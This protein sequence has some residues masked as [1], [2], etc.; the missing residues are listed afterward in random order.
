MINEISFAC[1][2]RELTCNADL[3]LAKPED[4]E[5]IHALARWSRS[6][7]RGLGNRSEY[8]IIL[9]NH[10]FTLERC[11]SNCDQTLLPGGSLSS[12]SSLTFPLSA[13]EVVFFLAVPQKRNLPLLES[14]CGLESGLI[15]RR[16]SNV[17]N[18]TAES[19]S[20]LT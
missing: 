19:S 11:Q 5:G 14:D 15:Y 16:R 10:M 6:R 18:S 12:T 7:L 3:S 2:L 20:S 1:L 17:A 8:V 9:L 13:F 4:L